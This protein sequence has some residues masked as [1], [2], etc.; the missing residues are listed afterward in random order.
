MM[1]NKRLVI[2]GTRSG[3]GKT[4][5]SLGL[6][7][8]LA[9]R[10]YQVQ[11][12]KVGPD[13]IDPGFHT[14]VTGNTSYNLDSYF[15]GNNGVKDLYL[16]TGENTDI[17]IIEGVMGLFDGKG[18]EGTGSTAEIARILKTPILLIIDGKKIAQSGAALAYG[19]K[20]YDSELN[21][22]G[23]ILNNIAS[24]RHYQLI[25]E[26]LE[27]KPVEL[28]VLGYIP[29]QK[30]LELPERHL[31]LV[32]THESKELELFIDNLSSLVE[33][34]VNLDKL[35]NLAGECEKVEPEKEI[36]YS[37]K[38]SRKKKYDLKIGIAY[39]K[40]FN[41]YYQYNLDLLEK[42]GAELIYF[43]PVQDE[44]L[45]DADG[46]YLGGGFP[47]SFLEQLA[48]N[49]DM[50]NDMKEKIEAGLPV[51]AEC[52]GLMYL[53]EEIIDTEGN[54]YPMVGVLSAQTKMTTSLQEMG[55][56]E[57]EAIT[58]NIMLN[59]K[60]KARG[61][62]F[63]YSRLDNLQE[64]IEHCY[65]GS[66][67]KLEGYSPVENLLISYIHL[68]FG[69]NPNLANNFLYNVSFM[70]FVRDDRLA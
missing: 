37:R 36:L 41:F 19:Y 30:D 38:K 34:H 5:I 3:V 60:E 21:I 7:A 26:A 13:Y 51:Y 22:K 18:K 54:V 39:D 68:H 70:K 10:G 25:K 48:N 20:N 15:L 45:P 66:G 46:L 29:R 24:K 57:I 44:R 4:T 1:G 32:P 16:N 8:A 27:S 63:H 53:S 42:L 67:N 61:H 23:V 14:L 43:S 50:K 55:Y 9:R 49:T 33:E 28:E 62:V 40:G 64:N 69:S 65:R 56:V 31:G 35:I 17:S 6:M 59:K 2:A 47:E 12:Y 52:G 58:S 11:P